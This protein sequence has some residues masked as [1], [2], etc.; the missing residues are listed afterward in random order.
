MDTGRVNIV[1]LRLVGVRR[2]Q[3]MPLQFL[4]ESEPAT[5]GNGGDGI[6]PVAYFYRG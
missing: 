1:L 4:N 3:F 6:I 2:T 5:G